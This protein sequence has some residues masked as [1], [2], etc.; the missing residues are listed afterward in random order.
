M[1]NNAYVLNLSMLFKNNQSHLLVETKDQ[2]S[3][4]KTFIH[5]ISDHLGIKTDRIDLL[6]YM[7]RGVVIQDKNLN[8]I[9]RPFMSNFKEPIENYKNLIVNSKCLTCGK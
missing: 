1:Q 5:Y 9:F 3:A 7:G 2:D 4:I 6:Q 8:T